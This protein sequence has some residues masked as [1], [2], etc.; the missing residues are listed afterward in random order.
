MAIPLNWLFNAIGQTAQ[1]EPY[2]GDNAKGPTYGPSVAM[3]CYIEQANN[4]I[5]DTEG[6]ELVST[7]KLWFPAGSSI[8][9][10]S[11]ITVGG[12]RSYALQVNVFSGGGLPTPDHVEVLLR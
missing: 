5:R 9:N 4:I 3:T 8:P 6:R 11:R 10:Q 12:L 7:S 1:V 2:L